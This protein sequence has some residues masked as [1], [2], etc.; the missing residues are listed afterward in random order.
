MIFLD[1]PYALSN[2][3]GILEIINEY[4][5]LTENGNLVFETAKEETLPDIVH[6]LK[7][8]KSTE[9]GITRITY[10]VKDVEQ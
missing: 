10:Y 8:V 1:P 9:Y 4:D 6:H 2:K 7:Q 3:A 5:L